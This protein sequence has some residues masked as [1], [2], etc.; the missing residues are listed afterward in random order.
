MRT[1][2]NDATATDGW[3]PK[4]GRLALRKPQD[5]LDDA[6][7]GPPVT[8]D[9]VSSRRGDEAWRDDVPPG[10]DRGP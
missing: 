8:L 7:C 3:A 1:A 10:P 4:S 2:G 9:F 6:S 5:L